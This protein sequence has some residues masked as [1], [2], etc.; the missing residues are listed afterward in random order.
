MTLPIKGRFA[1][2][3]TGKLHAGNIFAYLMAWLTVKSIGGSMV[4]R[5]EDLD[6]ERSK[7]YFADGVMSDLERL[8]LTW[9]EGP[10]YQHD[11]DGAYEEAY[12]ALAQRVD[13]YPCFCTRADLAAASAP[14]FGE[15]R[16]YPG[17]CKRLSASEAQDRMAAEDEPAWRIS[18][19][20]EQ[21]SFS[22]A[23][24]G[25]CSMDLATECGDFIIKRKDGAFAYQLAVVVDDAAQGVTSVVRGIDL[26][27]STPQQIYLQSLLG[28]PHPEYAHVPLLVSKSGRRLAKRDADASMEQML[29]RFGSPEGIIGHIAYIT[30]MQPEDAPASPEDLLK[31]FDMSKLSEAWKGKISI[32]W[33]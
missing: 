9:D 19:P 31:S 23:L 15:K 8:G 27:S 30:G 21:V 24:Q 33:E 25:Q 22:D 32:P 4:L 26:L 29:E 3:P 13:I 2:S 10:F 17:T 16:V 28:N 7:R 5:I 18:V 12:E 14:H 6:P 11:R 1:P 20:D